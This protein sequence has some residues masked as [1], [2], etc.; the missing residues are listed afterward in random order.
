MGPAYLALE[1]GAPLHVAFVRRAAGGWYRGG[2]ITLP[3]P[4]ADLPRRARIKALLDAEA[5]AFEE[6]IAVA[7]EQWWT[8][9]FPIWDGV[10]PRPRGRGGP[11]AGSAASGRPVG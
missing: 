3:H 2:L 4:P 6:F 5:R 7:P 8:V 9:F 1:H 10:G 11:P